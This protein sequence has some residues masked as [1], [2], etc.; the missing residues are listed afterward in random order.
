MTV[1][2][3]IFVVIF[4][5]HASVKAQ[6]LC[7]L[8]LSP[9]SPTTLRGPQDGRARNICAAGLPWQAVGHDPHTETMILALA[10]S[11]IVERP[12][13]SMEGGAFSPMERYASRR[14]PL[15]LNLLRIRKISFM[16]KLIFV[17]IGFIMKLI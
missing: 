6:S 4:R 8:L 2:L 15:V 13:I 3:F 17:E 16:L 12:A 10:M 5:F 1:L 7:L 9:Q 14:P 11:H